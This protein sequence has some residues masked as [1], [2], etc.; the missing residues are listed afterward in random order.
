M[1]DEDG[2]VGEFM[3]NEDTHNNLLI[4][5]FLVLNPINTVQYFHLFLAFT[6]T[7]HCFCFRLNG[8]VVEIQTDDSTDW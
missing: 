8:E 3:K 2:W 7:L 6:L 1:F 4:H 5:L